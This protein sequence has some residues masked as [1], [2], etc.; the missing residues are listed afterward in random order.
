[1]LIRNIVNHE[2]ILSMQYGDPIKLLKDFYTTI[3]F[4]LV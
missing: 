4:Q 2:Q 1:M 3:F